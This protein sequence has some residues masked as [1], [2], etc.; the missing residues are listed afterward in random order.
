MI[1]RRLVWIATIIDI[2]ICMGVT[3]YFIDNLLLAGLIWFIGGSLIGT[4]HYKV[5]NKVKEIE[6]FKKL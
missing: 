5:M 6:S 4:L 2:G 1:N 3:L